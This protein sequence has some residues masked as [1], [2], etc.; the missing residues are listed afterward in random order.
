MSDP[1]LKCGLAPVARADAKVL[2]L[3]S[4]PGEASLAAGQYYAHPTNQFWRLVGAALD[5]ELHTL[6]Y[7]HKVERLADRGV[8]LWDMVA[9]GRRRGSLDQHLVTHR[10][11]DIASLVASLPELRL[12]AFNGNKAGLLAS[13]LTSIDHVTRLQLPSSSAANTASFA[14]KL[15]YWRRIS[16]FL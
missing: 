9:E 11:Q 14:D 8:A 2:I 13:K 1:T 15:N 16:D 3:G 7:A 12:V 4:L 6:P 10:L 5:E